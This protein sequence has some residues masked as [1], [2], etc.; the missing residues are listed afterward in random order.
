[1]ALCAWLVAALPGGRAEDAAGPTA[2][3]WRAYT[4]QPNV[5]EY[6]LTTSTPDA[7]GNPILSFNHL[8]GKTEFVRVGERLGPYELVAFEPREEKVFN[9][10]I[11][12]YQTKSR[13]VAVL[14]GQGGEQIALVQGDPL[15]ADGLMACL[16]SMHSGA[17]Q[18]VQPGD[19]CSLDGV[20]LEVA[21]I[22]A[23]G[24]SVVT[25]GDALRLP[26]VTDAERQTIMSAWRERKERAAEQARVAA[27][28]REQAWERQEEAR[29]VRYQQ[30]ASRPK[31]PAGVFFG[32]EY[33]YPTE[34][35][36]IPFTTRSASGSYNHQAIVVPR[37]FE[38]RSVG[39]GYNVR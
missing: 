2:P 9:P 33:R 35:E 29:R 4:I 38:T 32:T 11:N 23:G 31:Q 19:R 20:D 36:V 39:M 6:M 28:E 13:S 34:Y 30:Q 10:T 24:V 18:Y 14:R 7:D 17:W 22:D 25:G 5:F 26:P 27:E 21:Q 3:P 8:S 15:A 37:R 16:V 12:A 1:L